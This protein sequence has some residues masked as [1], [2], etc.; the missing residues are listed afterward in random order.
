MF[1]D[2]DEHG[3]MD[4]AAVEALLPLPVRAIL[5][6]H[7]YGSCADTIRLGERAVQHG[8]ALMEDCAQ[9]HGASRDGVRAGARGQVASWSF[10]PTKN[11]AG[12]GGCGGGD[13]Q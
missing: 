12:A 8:L 13:V 11:L 6:V 1:V 4:V 5:C 3:L 10:Y 2:V 9:A 7:L